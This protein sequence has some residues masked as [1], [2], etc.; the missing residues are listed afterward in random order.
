MICAGHVVV[1][2][3]IGT[4][5]IVAPC[6]NV[7][8]VERRQA[9]TVRAIDVQH[10]VTLHLRSGVRGKGA[11]EY[12]ELDANQ[13]QFTIRLRLIDQSLR[14]RG[15]SSGPNAFETSETQE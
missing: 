2:V 4:P 10:Q 14:V 13:L 12:N 7:K 11:R 5:R 1:P 15:V 6:P 9:V 8:F 3:R